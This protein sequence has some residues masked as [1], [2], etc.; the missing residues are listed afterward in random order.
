MGGYP[1][2]FFEP[3]SSQ[4]WYYLPYD[5]GLIVH[6]ARHFIIAAERLKMIMFEVFFVFFNI[7]ALIIN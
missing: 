6:E 4:E 7:V 2:I 3:T 1:N 5:G